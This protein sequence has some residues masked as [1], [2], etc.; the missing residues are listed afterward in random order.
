MSTIRQGSAVKERKANVRQFELSHVISCEGGVG[1]AEC[2]ELVED[3]GGGHHPAD[4]GQEAEQ[5]EGTAG[6]DAAQEVAA[7]GEEVGGQHHLEDV[8]RKIVVDE[9]GPVVEEEWKVVEEVA[10]QQDFAGGAVRGE[11]GLGNVEY[12]PPSAEQVEDKEGAVEDQTAGACVPH[13]QV[14][15]QVNLLVGV[16]GDEVGDASGQERPFSGIGRKVVVLDILL[17]CDQHLEL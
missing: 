1:V 13:H 9:E 2:G 11:L 15:D 7:V 16:L 8:G 3:V 14:A 4:G 12:Q 10:G 6:D 17:V 5:A